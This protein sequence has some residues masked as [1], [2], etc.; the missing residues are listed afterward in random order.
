MPP[1]TLFRYIIL[2]ALFAVA[3]LALALTCLVVLV[4]LIE[5]LRFID[6][7]KNGNFGSALLLSV[8]RTPALVLTMLPF[9]FLFGS[10]WLF[11]QLNRRAEIAV[12]RSA[13][14]SVW[15]L[16]GPPAFLAALVGVLAIGLLDPVATSMRAQSERMRDTLKGATSS[17][18]RDFGDGIWLRQRDAGHILLINA[19]SIDVEKGVLRDV[20]MW[21]N[22]KESAFLERVDAP[23]A[24]L[25]GR[26]IEFKKARVK[27]AGERLDHRMPVY[28]IPTTLQLAD[29][30][31]RLE[32]PETLSLWRLPS[33]ILLA[34]AAGVPSIPYQI[35]FHDLCSTPLKLL[36]MVLI[37]ALFSLRPVRSGAGFQLFLTAVGAGFAL[38]VVSEMSTAL[39]ESGT[40]PIALAAWTPAIVAALVAV[41]GL[42]QFEDG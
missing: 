23:E 30:R 14:L 42:L 39:A 19:R 12:M 21:R 24:S 10:I 37:A 22:D 20:V 15:R 3:A 13:G 16:I 25:S 11:T 40:A 8:L 7:F 26:T 1:L 34:E 38:Y 41:T 33:F 5:N 18:M 6:K 32:S 36:A 17:I 31:E 27:E 9:V 2:R 28:A 35:R 29:L 4:D